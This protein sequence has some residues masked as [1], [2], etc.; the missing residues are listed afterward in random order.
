MKLSELI[1]DLKYTEIIGSTDME[2]KDITADSNAVGKNGLFVCI[3]GAGY[4]GHDFIKQVEDYGGV[5]AIVEKRLDTR[6]TQIVVNSA[7]QAMSEIA[8]AFYGHADKKM[9]LIGV[10]GT[11]GK[12]TTTHL[13]A[14]ILMNS[15]VK[16][17]LVGTL[18]IFY[19]NKFIEPTLTT[20]DP[21]ELHKTLADMYD[22]GVEAVVM[23][24]SAH[25]AFLKKVY[26]LEFETGV[27][28]NLTQDHLDFFGDMES[29]KKAKTSFFKDNACKYVVLNSDD[30]TGREI[31]QTA[32]GKVLTYGIDSPADVFAIDLDEKPSETT[33]VLNLFDC[34]YEVRLNLIGRYN[35]YNALAAATVCALYGIPPEKVAEGIE[36]LKGVSGRLECVYDGDF[37]VYID[38]AHTP[39]GLKQSLTALK[40]H[41]KNRL[42]CLFGC[43]GN[44]DKE[45]RPIMGA[46][47]GEIADFT[48]LTSDNPRY[49]EPMEILWQVEK[50]IVE[51]TDRYVIVQERAEGIR[52]ALD[53]AK[54]GDIVLLAGKGSEKYQEVF[55][56]KRPFCDKDY[57]DGYLRRKK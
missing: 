12:T 51:K 21:I 44:R 34:I 1:K 31:A 46:I 9:K 33:F 52:Y 26:G 40:R 29:Y 36:N 23:E 41:T 28:T 24:V 15:G 30:E 6:L 27:F 14:S 38:Y 37:S 56:I 45:K 53:M 7:R 25:A 42:I 35:V 2:I 16:C 50:G 39:D 43:G 22:S 20:P 13:I 47:S 32:K 54:K 11:N 18:G 48:V 4:D 3:S 5:A 55:G 10:L 17:G 8:A 49:E 19:G 57:V